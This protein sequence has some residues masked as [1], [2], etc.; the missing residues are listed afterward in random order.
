MDDPNVHIQPIGR[1][2]K[3]LFRGQVLV[4]LKKANKR[5][6]GSNIATQATIEFI[7]PQL[8][9][10]ELPPIFHVEVLYEENNLATQIQSVSAACR[11]GNHRLWS[12]ELEK[13][14]AAT[15]T[16]LATQ[17]V[18][19]PEPAYVQPREKSEKPEDE[20]GR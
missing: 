19:N 5:G 8:P 20:R 11:Q 10:L 3:F 15:V 1:T 2:V 4:R 6:L 13:P 12:Y 18:V 7:D 17:V 9:L 14:S 16:P